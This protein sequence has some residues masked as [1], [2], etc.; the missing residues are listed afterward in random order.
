M[1]GTDTSPSPSPT[2]DIQ[3]RPYAPSW[4]DRLNSIIDRLPRPSWV[5]YLVIGLGIFLIQFS[6]LWGERTN[7][8]PGFLFAQAFLSG[9]IVLFPALQRYLDRKAGEALEALQPALEVDDATLGAL[10]YR[11]VTLPAV[12]TLLACLFAA[13]AIVLINE[14]LGTPTGFEEVAEFPLS[15]AMIYGMY[16]LV[17]WVWG[18]FL[19]HTIHQ[20]RIINLIYTKHTSINLFRLGPLYSFSRITMLTAVSQTVP[21]Y[22][23]LAVIGGLRD[24]I[25]MGITVPIAFLAVVAFVWPLTGIHRLLSDE[26]GR[27]LDE[28]AQRFEAT[29]SELHKSVDSGNL[30]GIDRV[31]LAIAS[32]EMERNALGR[33]PTWPWQ[34]ET[35]RLLITALAL[36]LGLWIIQIVLQRVMAP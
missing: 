11:L 20:L 5:Y 18:G 10:R 31:N 28:A 36:P 29:V 12:P 27:L 3:P 25:A 13:I 22:A 15:R 14:G 6:V 7:P 35:V 30:K 32:L 26:K 21:T 33:I 34:A 2:G 1:A 16:V 8:T 24:P 4:I 19:F 17:W 9:M 23:W